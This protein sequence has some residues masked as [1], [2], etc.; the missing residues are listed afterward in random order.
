MIRCILR[1]VVDMAL[2][3]NNIFFVG[4]SLTFDPFGEGKPSIGAIFPHI[5]CGIFLNLS[6]N[7]EKNVEVEDIEKIIQKVKQSFCNQCIVNRNG[8]Q[9]E[10]ETA[11]AES[12]TTTSTSPEDESAGGRPRRSARR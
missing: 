3:D 12:T 8:K 5:L 9:P 6:P 4:S 10:E 1:H 2:D 11:E 7:C